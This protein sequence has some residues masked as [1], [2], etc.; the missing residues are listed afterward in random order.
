MITS[1]KGDIT[2][3]ETGSELQAIEHRSHNGAKFTQVGFLGFSNYEQ[4]WEFCIRYSKSVVCPADIKDKPEIIMARGIYGN[5]IGLKFMQSINSIM[6]VNGRFT[7]YGDMPLALCMRSPDFEYIRENWDKEKKVATCVVKSR[8]FKEENIRTFGIENVKE[9]GLRNPLYNSCPDVMC[10]FRARS[11]LRDTFPDVLCGMI[12]SEEAED[13]IDL[14]PVDTKE[15]INK[16][17]GEIAIT[18]EKLDRAKQLFPV[19]PLEGDA[20]DGSKPSDALTKFDISNPEH[21]DA[22]EKLEVLIECSSDPVKTREAIVAKCAIADLSEMSVENM[23]HWN[24]LLEKRIA[25]RS[26]AGE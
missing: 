6:N 22:L 14:N 23:I 15:S 13:F 5:E 24:G 7:L 18:K 21:V 1:T 9:R 2:M 12:G 10:K 19:L 20:L 11:I 3:N 26:Q 25:Q 16:E 8:R 4:A 17:T